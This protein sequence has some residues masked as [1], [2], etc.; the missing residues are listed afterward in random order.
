MAEVIM[1]YINFIRKRRAYIPKISNPKEDVLI[2]KCLLKT[3]EL[4]KYLFAFRI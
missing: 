1:E 2:G 3:P 4:R